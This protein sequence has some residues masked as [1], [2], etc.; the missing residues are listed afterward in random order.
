MKRPKTISFEDS[1]FNEAK[2]QI[3]PNLEK[4][5]F[6]RVVSELGNICNMMYNYIAKDNDFY[7]QMQIVKNLQRRTA[8]LQRTLPKGIRQ[9]LSE[10]QRIQNKM[11][12]RCQS[13]FYKDVEENS[14]PEWHDYCGNDDN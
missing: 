4:S 13:L 9:S 7:G 14:D 5:Q 6:D 1:I 10:I 12:G 3:Q 11:F 8:K 2:R